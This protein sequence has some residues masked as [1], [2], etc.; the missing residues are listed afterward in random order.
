S[1]LDAVVESAHA[2]GLQLI[3]QVQTTGGWSLPTPAM[4]LATTGFRTNSLHPIPRPTTA[5]PMNIDAAIPYWRALVGRYRAGGELARTQGW[6]DGWGVRA[7]EME[8]EPDFTPWVNGTWE[9]VTKDYALYVA[10]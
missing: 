10:H 9:T 3:V 1:G 5:A 6:R 8:N 2:H 7:Y 4:A